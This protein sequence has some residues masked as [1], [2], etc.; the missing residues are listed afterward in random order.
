MTQLPLLEP[1]GGEL[2]P[3]ILGHLRKAKSAEGDA[4]VCIA[5][6]LVV[7]AESY[8]Q[9]AAAHYLEADELE[10]LAMFE[11]WGEVHS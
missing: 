11:A 7:A 8:R 4:A 3:L 5:R 9:L 1:T 2:F 6:G 10:S